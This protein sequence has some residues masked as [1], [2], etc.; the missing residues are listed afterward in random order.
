MA[1]SETHLCVARSR[2]PAFDPARRQVL[3][4]FA[5][6]D[7]RETLVGLGAIDCGEDAP[8]VLVVDERL[9]AGL[10]EVLSR[11]PVERARPRHAA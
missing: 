2:S 1:R 4:A 11:V 8:D 3:C 9:A 7:G 10:G 6:L 5:A